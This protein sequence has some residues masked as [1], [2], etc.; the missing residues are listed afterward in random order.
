[1]TKYEIRLPWCQ[2]DTMIYVVHNYVACPRGL[3]VSSSHMSDISLVAY[4][5]IPGSPC[6]HIAVHVGLS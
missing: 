5:Y 4:A 1:M 3:H 6:L 2:V